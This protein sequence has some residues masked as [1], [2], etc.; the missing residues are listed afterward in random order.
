MWC[1][2]VSV[3]VCDKER[4]RDR[5]ACALERRKC[6]KSSNPKIALVTENANLQGHLVL[7][8]PFSLQPV[9]L[10][11]S[12]SLTSQ[13][14]SPHSLIQCLSRDLKDNVAKTLG[15][16]Q[17]RGKCELASAAGAARAAEAAAAN[18]VQILFF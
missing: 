1:A 7:S 11:L 17:I 3:C 12:I 9:L 8:S 13:T 10:S 18:A 5:G 4:E 16:V 15:P 6:K 2:G 14:I